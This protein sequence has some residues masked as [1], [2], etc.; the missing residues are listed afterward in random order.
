MVAFL[1][2][3]HGLLVLAF[4]EAHPWQQDTATNPCQNMVDM[5]VQH[6][7]LQEEQGC[8]M[9]VTVLVSFKKEIHNL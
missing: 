8:V 3:R 6:W 7:D 4:V 1:I 9:K 5:I 2:G